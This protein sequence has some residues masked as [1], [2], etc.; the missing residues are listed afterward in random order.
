MC[1]VLRGL[2]LEDLVGYHDW[3]MCFTPVAKHERRGPPLQCYQVVHVVGV[4]KSLR[5]QVNGITIQHSA[6]RGDTLDQEG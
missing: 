3:G 6:L 4:A 1:G 5:V 2:P